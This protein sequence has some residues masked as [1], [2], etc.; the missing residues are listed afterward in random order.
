MISK[1][2]CA[3]TFA[4]ILVTAASWTLSGQSGPVTYERLLKADAE[5]GNWL[6]YQGT[7]AGW[8]FSKLNQITSQNVKNLRL[9]WMFQGRHQEK[10]E[11]TP[12]R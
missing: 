4:A 8:R 6:M 5:P 11:T 1:R 10:F 7:Y 3:W 2:A 12:R 9:K